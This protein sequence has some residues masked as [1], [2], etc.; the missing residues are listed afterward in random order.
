MK[1]YGNS[2]IESNST[3]SL[4]SQTVKKWY[5]TLRNPGKHNFHASKQQLSE[6]KKKRKVNFLS[7]IKNSKRNQIKIHT[8]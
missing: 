2:N 8:C 1:S 6:S 7:E 3:S 5:E 4:D